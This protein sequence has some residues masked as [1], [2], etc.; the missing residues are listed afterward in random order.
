[1][2]FVSGALLK[3]LNSIALLANAAVCRAVLRRPTIPVGQPIGGVGG[4]VILVAYLLPITR[5]PCQLTRF[6]K[7]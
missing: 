4:G 2:F 7:P 5:K 3:V 1:M 6:S